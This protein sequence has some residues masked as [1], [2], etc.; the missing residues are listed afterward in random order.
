PQALLPPPGGFAEKGNKKGKGPD[1][2]DPKGTTSA[3][4]PMTTTPS[5]VEGFLKEFGKN[6][7][8]G[9]PRIVALGRD[10]EVDDHLQA[11]AKYTAGDGKDGDKEAKDKAEKA[12]EA[13]AERKALDKANDAIT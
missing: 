9:G 11:A 3:P 5:T 12:K 4:A 1:P 2:K 13:L 6:D 7:T 8:T 10:K